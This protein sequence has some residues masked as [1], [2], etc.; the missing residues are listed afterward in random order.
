MI[1]KKA[2]PVLEHYRNFIV[3][4]LT[5]AMISVSLAA[6]PHPSKEARRTA[7]GQPKRCFVT[8]DLSSWS[9]QMPHVN[10]CQDRKERL[11][12]PYSGKSWS[13]NWVLTR[14]WTCS[15]VSKSLW[16][17]TTHFSEALCYA[18]CQVVKAF[19]G[20]CHHLKQALPMFSPGLVLMVSLQTTDSFRCVF[21]PPSTLCML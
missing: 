17:E 13:M 5:P 18:V 9:P 1:F 10:T 7:A 8:I 3:C 2:W 14:C 6:S 4:F 21:C 16:V 11:F 20:K 15:H 19:S 12:S